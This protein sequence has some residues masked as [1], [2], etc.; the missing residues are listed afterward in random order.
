VRVS[1]G[2]TGAPS[3]SVFRPLSQ[4]RVLLTKPSFE[5]DVEIESLIRSLPI[6]VSDTP[7][8]V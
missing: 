6:L 1:L 3:I 2:N 5:I 8:A 7:V 4:V